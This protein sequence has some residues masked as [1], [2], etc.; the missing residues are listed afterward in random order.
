MRS[1]NLVLTLRIKDSFNLNIFSL[2]LYKEK[3]LLLTTSLK[4]LMKSFMS[5]L[6]L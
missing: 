6:L 5:E 4:I 3:F 2:I 1:T